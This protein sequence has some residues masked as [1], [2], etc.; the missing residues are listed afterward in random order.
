MKQQEFSG[1]DFGVTTERL[2]LRPIVHDDA[3]AIFKYR[4][5]AETNRFQGWIPAILEEVH[6]FIEHR[7]A[8]T[9]NLPDTW[10]QFAIILRSNGELVGDIGVHFIGSQNEQIELGCTL[11]KIQQGNGYAREALQKLI[12]FLFVEHEK[13]K[14]IVFIHPENKS[15]IRLFEGLG[16]VKEQT[17]LDVDDDLELKFGL[18]AKDFLFRKRKDHS[19]K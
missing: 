19:T 8:K 13:E 11:H 12:E 3:L 2:L 7:I 5:D 1:I 18:A 4:S 15:S 17:L 9:F 10:V 16:F 6:Y 14:L